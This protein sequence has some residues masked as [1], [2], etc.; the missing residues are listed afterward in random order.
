[1]ANQYDFFNLMK[2]GGYNPMDGGITTNQMKDF[3][4]Q[5]LINDM[6]QVNEKINSLNLPPAQE[7]KSANIFQKIGSAFGQYGMDNRMAADDFVGLPKDQRR[8]M[9][10]QGL[11][12]FANQ[13]NLIGAQQSGNPQ[14][15]AL[16]QQNIMNFQER[17]KQQ[18]DERKAEANQQNLTSNALTIAKANG[19]T[20]EQL[21]IIAKDPAIARSVVQS[22]LKPKENKIP[23]PAELIKQ[24]E[25]AVLRRLEEVGGDIDQLTDYQQGIYK[26]YIEKRDPPLNI[27]DLLLQANQDEDLII[28]KVE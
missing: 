18:E 14:R 26:N 8:A 22:S 24:E 21:A 19:A 25:L 9:Q 11:Q 1:M 27:V 16:A 4:L 12:N 5:G 3:R 6:N 10:M 20:D 13:M 7:K 15:V 17:K 2:S 23:S 28:N